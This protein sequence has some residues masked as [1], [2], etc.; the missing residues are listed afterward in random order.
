[1]TLYELTKKYSAGKGEDMMWKT[2]SLVSDSVESSMQPCDRKK[3]I[4][5]VYCAMSGG[6]YNE[7][8][9]HEDIESMFF[10]DKSGKQHPAPYW[11]TQTIEEVYDGVKDE[12]LDY[13]LWDF[14]VTMNMLASDNWCLLERWFPGITDKERNAKLVEMAVNWLL[15]E[16]A[17]HP[18]S[19]IWH[20]MNG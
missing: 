19:K 8:F 16:D 13:N 15:D 10:T 1:M 2:L 12:I 3:L 18:D 11:S 7:E 20:Y 17:K 6:H 5:K 14:A 9:A 4:R